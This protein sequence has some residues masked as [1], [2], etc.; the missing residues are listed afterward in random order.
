MASAWVGVE[1]ANARQREIKEEKRVL[2]PVSLVPFQRLQEWA[3][4]DADTGK[5]AAREVRE[6]FIPD[7]SDWK[8]SDAYHASFERLLRDLHASE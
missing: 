5:D 2:F 1:I 8:D 6:Y 3:S 7:F 4:F